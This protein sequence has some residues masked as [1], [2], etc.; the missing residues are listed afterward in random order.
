MVDDVA[1][2]LQDMDVSL[3]RRAPGRGEQ[4]SSYVH[5]LLDLALLETLLELSLFCFCQTG[6]SNVNM[7]KRFWGLLDAYPSILP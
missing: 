2:D 1:E 4:G 6:D 5:E 3:S 7:T